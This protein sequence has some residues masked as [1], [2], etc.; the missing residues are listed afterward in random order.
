MSPAVGASVENYRR[1][2]TSGRRLAPPRAPGGGT[3][4]SPAPPR[5]R[6]GALVEVA[7]DVDALL[8]HLVADGLH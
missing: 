4:E 8:A 1:R 6:S 3:G 5:M 2:S 7:L